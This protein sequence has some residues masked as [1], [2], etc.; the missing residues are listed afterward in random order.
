MSPKPRNMSA[1]LHFPLLK[2]SLIFSQMP[3]IRSLHKRKM[4]PRCLLWHQFGKK[5]CNC[6]RAFLLQTSL[7]EDDSQ[8][9]LYFK[10]N[11]L[12]PKTGRNSVSFSIT[13]GDLYLYWVIVKAQFTQNYQKIQWKKFLKWNVILFVT[14]SIKILKD[15]YNVK[16]LCYC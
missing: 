10:R 3:E 11:L 8:M 5:K 1:S 16:P 9:S 6:Q 15:Q 4:F 7:C 14:L 2:V 13:S 12:F